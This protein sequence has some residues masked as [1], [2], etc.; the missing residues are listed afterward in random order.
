MYSHVFPF[1]VQ[2]LANLEGL[3]FLLELIS[4]CK[5]WSMQQVLLTRTIETGLKAL[6]FVA[7]NL[8][9]GKFFAPSGSEEVSYQLAY[10]AYI[11]FV[12][13]QYFH[14]PIDA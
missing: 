13:P 10:L 6:E 3:L 5:Q 7:L 11:C 4:R 14:F 8:S 12:R 1:I 2:L 9:N